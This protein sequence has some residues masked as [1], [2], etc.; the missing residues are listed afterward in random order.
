VAALRP[1]ARAVPP[2]RVA[3]AFQIA[4]IAR[5]MPTNGRTKGER[6]RRRVRRAAGVRAGGRVRVPVLTRQR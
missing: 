3:S 6:R 2:I 1:A 5:P 4:A